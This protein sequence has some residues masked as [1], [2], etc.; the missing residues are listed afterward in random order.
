MFILVLFKQTI[1]VLPTDME[2]DVQYVLMDVC[3]YLKYVPCVL[4]I[5]LTQGCVHSC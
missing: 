4:H 5:D 3:V 1:S 2:E